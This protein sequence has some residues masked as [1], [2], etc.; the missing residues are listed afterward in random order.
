MEIHFF[1]FF[2]KKA[3]DFR[4]LCIYIVKVL[5][6]EMVNNMTKTMR[7]MPAC[8]LAGIIAVAVAF[9]IGM[10]MLFISQSRKGMPASSYW[11]L[12]LLFGKMPE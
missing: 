1:S 2:W 7:K 3:G 9:A 12:Q 4:I 10:L 11:F 8:L 6:R 5:S